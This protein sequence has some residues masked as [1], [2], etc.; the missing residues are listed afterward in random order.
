MLKQDTSVLL[1]NLMESREARTGVRLM[2][3]RVF[4]MYICGRRRRLPCLAGVVYWEAGR[5]KVFKFPSVL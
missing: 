4:C 5:G 1:S 3:V 2:A